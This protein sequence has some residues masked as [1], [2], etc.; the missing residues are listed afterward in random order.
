MTET[1][2]VQEIRGSFYLYLPKSWCDE[3]QIEKQQEI[4]IEVLENNNLLLT[5][6]KN[7]HPLIGQI[8][9]NLDEWEEENT[10]IFY[11]IFSSYISGADK[12]IITSEKKIKL[13]LRQQIDKMVRNLID[14]EILEEDEYKIV[15]RTLGQTPED[16]K[17]IFQRML[18][19]VLYML[20]PFSESDA[21]SNESKEDIKKLE[22][23]SE[24]IISRHKDVKRF[25]SFIERGIHML[26]RN[27]NQ[28]RQLKWSVNDCIFNLMVVKY[29]EA[30][31]GHG[32]KIAELIPEI[33]LNGYNNIKELACG[34]Y[35][36]FKDSIIVYQY[37]NMMEAYKIFNNHTDI[38]KLDNLKSELSTASN[39][40]VYH[41]KRIISY[42]RRI[43]EL[44]VHKYISKTVASSRTEALQKPK[45]EEK[46]ES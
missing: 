42:S 30:I 11:L 23:S 14:L 10:D 27:R 38:D 33:E 45:L 17:N 21:I 16:I 13:Q 46:K 39:L 5:N 41:L 36:I 24:I 4:S 34:A 1:R 6:K 3:N 28:L 8:S 31:A 2:K 7:T 25:A 40:M 15:I 20:D 26:L 43:A 18:N 12:I 29:A 9:I 35:N 44:A 37:G 32:S 22:K 19:N